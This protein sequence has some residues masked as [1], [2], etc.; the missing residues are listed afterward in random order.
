MARA[1]DARLPLPWGRVRNGVTTQEEPNAS[2]GR[3]GALLA[4]GD[5][6]GLCSRCLA[7]FMLMGRTTLSPASVSDSRGVGTGPQLSCPQCG[8]AIALVGGA[9]TSE[10]VAE[11]PGMSG[12]EVSESLGAHPV[13]DRYQILEQI[14][15]GGFGVVYLAEQVAPIRRQVALKVIKAG[16]DSR[17]VVV[18]FRAEQ[19]ALALL[20]HPNVAHV[21]DAGA[22]RAG[23]PYFAMELVRGLPITE[24]CRSL[25]LGVAERLRLF[26][27]ACRAVQHAHQKGIIHRDLKPANIMVMLD[28]EAAIP[29]V[30]DFGIAKALGYS[31]TER[32]LQTRQGQPL[33]TPAYASPEQLGAIVLDVDTRSDIYSLGVVLYELL[34]GELPFD[35]DQ[36]RQGGI[37]EVQQRLLREEPRKPS[38]CLGARHRREKRG[39][40]DRLGSRVSPTAEQLK[41]DL[42]WI[43]MRCLEKNRNRRY[44]S[45]SA[46][47]DDLEHH[48]LHSFVRGGRLSAAGREH[49]GFPCGGRRVADRGGRRGCAR[50]A[51]QSGMR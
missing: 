4:V 30:I 10:S 33:G 21:Y 23:R 47:A 5:L 6:E 43:V 40:D 35:F 24:H 12:G 29:K 17:E 48:L 32:T 3:C 39:A 13:V 14:G 2:C 51:D 38:T 27:A 46:L 20:D 15:E 25:G 41:G 28:G 31:L 37:A 18:R 36:W 26:I 34:T 42:D 50:E 44:E 1:G 45:A 49:G 9:S 8:H 7:R 19:Q 16:M 11:A 22:T